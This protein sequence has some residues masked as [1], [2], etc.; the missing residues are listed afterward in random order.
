MVDPW[1]WLGEA[2]SRLR[3]GKPITRKAKPRH[4][5]QWKSA[6]RGADK[7]KRLGQVQVIK[8]PWFTSQLGCGLGGADS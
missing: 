1:A 3:A 4:A 5:Q 8:V 2:H 6:S 7:L